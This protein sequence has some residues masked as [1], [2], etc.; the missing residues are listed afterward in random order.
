MAK[1][2]NLSTGGLAPR[3]YGLRVAVYPSDPTVSVE[4]QAAPTTAF[5]SSQTLNFKYPPT[6]ASFILSTFEVPYSTS[7]WYTRARPFK[8]GYTTGAFTGIVSDTPALLQE[9]MPIPAHTATRISSLD[10]PQG[11][12]LPVPFGASLFTGSWGGIGVG[13]M[14]VAFSWTSQTLRYPDG[15]TLT[16]PAPPAGIA[17]AAGD[18]N[19]VAGGTRGATTLFA[20]RGLVKDGHVYALSGSQSFAV[21]ANNRLT[22]A[23]PTAVPGYDGWCVMVDSGSGTTVFLQESGGTQ[24]P[25]PFG[26]NYTEPTAHFSNAA[27]QYTSAWLNAVVYV[28]L[29]ANTTYYFY[30]TF[31]IARGFARFFPAGDAIGDTAPSMAD[32]ALAWLDG[33]I[34]LSGTGM[35]IAVGAGGGSGSPT[36]G[37]SRLT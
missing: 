3:R 19:Q 9:M 2:A 31:D 1:P 4:V 15:S 11:S 20:R 25:I 29:N 33:R 27:A 24:F 22:V 34:A 18:L 5:A 17:L 23:A 6:A 10:N 7:L 30:P 26:T 35:Q 8:A 13:Q 32:A 37:G 21:S 16:L 28:D 12:V 14:F 36:T